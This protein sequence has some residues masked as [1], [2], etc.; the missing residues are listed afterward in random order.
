M[1]LLL[2][3]SL[4][5]AA[6]AH[7]DCGGDCLKACRSCTCDL[8]NDGPSTDDGESPFQ[9]GNKYSGDCKQLICK[10]HNASLIVDGKIYDR[11]VC[12][13][14]AW[15]FGYPEFLEEASSAMCLNPGNRTCP[16]DAEM[17]YEDD[18]KCMCKPDFEDMSDVFPDAPEDILPLCTN[19]GKKK[20]R[21]TFLIDNS[22][23]M[24]SVI[25]EIKHFIGQLV[26]FLKVSET[27]NNIAVVSSAFS[28]DVLINWG[29][30][31]H[32]ESAIHDAVDSID[33]DGQS[34]LA[35]GL[36]AVKAALVQPTDENTQ[37]KLVVFT[38]GSIKCGPEALKSLARAANNLEHLKVETFV[39][40]TNSRYTT[41]LHAIANGVEDNVFSIS[42]EEDDEMENL[43]VAAKLQRRICA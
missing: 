14:G 13:Q 34:Y 32:D 30:Q 22:G 38:D 2:F 20:L 7:G 23:S 37:H 43:K 39:V 42:S 15:H 40:A 9:I 25:H 16:D 41:R 8:P 28:Y 31:S 35:T 4:L 36:E 24:A 26:K 3:V 17:R 33:A 12:F 11:L 29:E 1:K 27:G 5:A 18:F 6:Y 19:C 21:I 10:D